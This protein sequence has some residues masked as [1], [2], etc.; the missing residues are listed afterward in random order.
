MIRAAASTQP[1]C[2]YS[3]IAMPEWICSIDDTDLVN[4]LQRLLTTF[5]H[6][7]PSQQSPE[8]VSKFLVAF[9]ASPKLKIEVFANEH[10]PPHFRVKYAGETANY[11]IGDCEQINGGL[12]RYYRIIRD[13]HSKH[14]A[15]L[16]ESWN[17]FRP[18]DCPVGEYVET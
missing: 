17:T 1:L 9:T 14:K 6:F 7:A 16:V 13:W 3:I 15:K 5:D 12:Q 4:E 10:P 8:I 11:R 18:T 2:A